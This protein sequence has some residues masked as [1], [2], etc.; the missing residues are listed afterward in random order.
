MPGQ[1]RSGA[2]TQ[3]EGVDGRE[4]QSLVQV[5]QA[6]AQLALQQLQTEGVVAF[7][8]NGIKFTWRQEEYP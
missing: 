4:F 6:A 2:Q 1:A 5:L 7:P 3:E 8:R